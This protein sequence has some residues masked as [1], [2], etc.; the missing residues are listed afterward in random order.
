M[1]A[2]FNGQCRYQNETKCG[3]I[4]KGQWI[5]H[6]GRGN[7]YHPDCASRTP[8]EN[9]RAN[10]EGAFYNEGYI[11]WAFDEQPTDEQVVYGY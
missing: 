3:G 2:K 5:T 8:A 11:H 4:L 1:K 9:D 10:F 6:E 7:T